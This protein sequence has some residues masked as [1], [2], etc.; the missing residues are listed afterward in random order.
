ML[1]SL[2]AARGP[3]YCRSNGGAASASQRRAMSSFVAGGKSALAARADSGACRASASE[4]KVAT[5]DR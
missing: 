5:N 4:V 2:S 3:L 1:A